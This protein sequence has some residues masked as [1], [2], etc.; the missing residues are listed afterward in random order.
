MRCRIRQPASVD[1]RPQTGDDVVG[2]DMVGAG[3]LGAARCQTPSLLRPPPPASRDQKQTVR[4]HVLRS[5]GAS[6]PGSETPSRN[7]GPQ[8]LFFPSRPERLRL[9]RLF[10]AAENDSYLVGRDC[11]NKAT[12]QVAL[13]L[14][15][16]SGQE[17]KNCG[18][19]GASAPPECAP[20]L[21]PL[22]AA[23]GNL[24]GPRGALW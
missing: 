7:C 17:E 3:V 21:R 14:K 24:H 22:P 12:L 15:R 6:R 18:W 20:S 2:V 10:W 1:K 4:K 13:T 9:R 19:R 8:C 5:A 11:E 23:A 16:C